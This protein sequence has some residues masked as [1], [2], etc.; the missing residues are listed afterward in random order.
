[1]QAR[2]FP[3]LV[4]ASADLFGLTACERPTPL[5]TLYSGETSINDRAFSYCFEGQD[6]AKEPGTPGAC[7]FDTEGRTAKVLE[8][9]PGDEVVVDVD[10]DLAHTG[11][12]VVLRAPGGQPSRLAIQDEHVTSFQ[13]DFSR[14]PQITLEVLKLDRKAED[15]RAVGVWQFALVPG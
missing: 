14:S 5:V 7:R 6:P 11:W 8:V 13:P 10:R 3:A 12:T 15:A 4:G 9:D 1:M 2:R